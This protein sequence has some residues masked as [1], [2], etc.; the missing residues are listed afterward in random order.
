VGGFAIV[1]AGRD[2]GEGGEVVEQRW[3]ESVVLEEVRVKREEGGVSAATDGTLYLTEVPH[4][5]RRIT[6][7]IPPL[8]QLAGVAH[9]IRQLVFARL[10]VPRRT[11]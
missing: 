9:L 6:P 2:H 8:A 4:T 5:R 7:Q 10:V 1:E 11:C 3:A